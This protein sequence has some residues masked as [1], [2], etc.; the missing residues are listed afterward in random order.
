V[1][2]T[3]PRLGI[4]TCLLGEAVRYDGGHK[5]DPLLVDT[6]GPFVEWVPVCPELECGLGLPREAMR[7]EGD[8]GAP[9]LVTVRTRRDLTEPM[10][11]WA[12]RRVEEL[13]GEGLCGFVFKSNSPSCGLEGVDVFEPDGVA[14]KVGVGLFARAFMR[15]FPALPAA[16]EERLHD[17]D[18]RERF[19][20]RV[21][22]RR[23]R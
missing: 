13:A 6:F 3:K 5:R 11:A 17:P 23:H 4:S 2:E 9:R 19:I 1:S 21:F 15:R 16:Q 7:L 18:L 14:R 10:L 20:E 22:A 12:R 8:P